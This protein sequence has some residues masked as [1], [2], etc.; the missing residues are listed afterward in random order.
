MLC[1]FFQIEWGAAGMS[2]TANIFVFMTIVGFFVAFDNDDVDY[3][4][5]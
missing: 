5:W 2:V 3:S 1:F 4:M